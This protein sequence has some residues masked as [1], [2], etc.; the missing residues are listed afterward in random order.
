MRAVATAAAIALAAGA[1]AHARATPGPAPVRAMRLRE[2]RRAVDS[3]V[4]APE[5]RNANWGVLIADPAAGDTLYSRNAGKL[6]MP[7]SNQKLLTGS[8]ALTQLGPDFRF[9][10]RFA[11]AGHV[12]DGALHGD[13]VV[14]G[15]GDPTF[16][17]TLQGGD[18]RNAFRAMADSVAARGITRI[19]GVL[20]R[21]GPAFTDGDCGYGW[22]L[23][24]LD[25]PYGAC[26]DELFVNEG[27][28]R[29]P[30]DDRDTT[31]TRAVA[32][33]DPRGA[34]F[35]ALGDAL[36]EKGVTFAG[37]ADSARVVP[38][39]GLT[40]LFAIASPPLPVILARMLKPSQN[41]IAELLFKT[42]GRVKGGAGRADSARHVVERQLVAWGADSAGFAVRDGSGMSRHDFVSPETLVRVLDA[43]R[44]GPDAATWYASLPV[45]GEPGT[46]E[47]R[48]LGTA[49]ERKVHAKTGTV[50]KARTLSGYVTTA[51]GRTLVFSFLCN[52]FTVPT[53]DVERVQDAILAL[54]AARPRPI[55]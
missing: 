49:A 46:L 55:R 18:F 16:S 45:A 20:V 9:T 43:M 3:M 23:D 1:C 34:F 36:H 14:L 15:T 52:N 22:E 38:D 17:D 5:F 28:A 21:G 37:V 32:I 4:N 31:A 19:E 41:Q 48:M 26:V 12:A 44:R 54:L 10:T 33:R 11:T 30:R 24:D 42:L 8:T 25:E 7:A 13:L 47:T 29:V 35:A 51:D 27:Y 40:T 6:F 2:F 50:D 53:R 39:S